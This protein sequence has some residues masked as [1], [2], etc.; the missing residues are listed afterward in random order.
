[1]T[2]KELSRETKIVHSVHSESAECMDHVAPLH[3]TSTFKFKNADH[4]ADLFAGRDQGFIYTRLGNPTVAML[5]QKLAV[6]EEGEAAIATASGMSAIASVACTLAKPGDNFVTC[7]S[8][9]GGTFAL[10]NRHMNEFSITPRFISPA[11]C[12]STSCIEALIDDKTRFLYIETPANPTLDIIDIEMWGVVAKNAGIPLVVDNTFPTPYLCRPLTIGADIVVHSMTK[13]LSGHGDIVGGAIIGKKDM[14]Y[15]INKGFVHNFGPTMSPFNAWL[16]TRGIKTLALRM[17]KHCDNALAV[18]EFLEKHPKVEKVFYPGLK[19]NP[20]F[21]LTKKQMKKAGGMISFIVKGGTQAG[22]T[23]M[24][25]VEVCTL[26]VSL[27]DCDTLIQHPASMTHTA[28]TKEDREKA[29]IADGLI[30]LSVGIED[31]VDIID[32]LDRCLTLI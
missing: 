20:Y 14:M 30:R 17:E 25:N 29:G 32:D 13:Y 4:G 24:D 5:E 9:Y 3:M 15:R 2:K 19:S 8:L 18:A 27:G 23:I 31:V 12:V 22:K 1:M 11:D 26:A 6:I 10:F 16:F 7:N 28:Y 21:E